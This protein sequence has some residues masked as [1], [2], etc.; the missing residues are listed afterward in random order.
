MN[1]D[2]DSATDV[3]DALINY[4]LEGKRWAQGSGQ[5]RMSVEEEGAEPSEID[6]EA[7]VADVTG[8]NESLYTVHLD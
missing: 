3:Y 8:S 4:Q 6:E 2:I 5:D 1:V 7:I